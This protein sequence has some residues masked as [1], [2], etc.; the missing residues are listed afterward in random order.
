MGP[1]RLEL[2]VKPDAVQIFEAALVVW[3][4]FDVIEQVA[5]LGFRQ[6]VESLAWLRRPQF[7]IWLTGFACLLLASLR[8]QTG[9]CVFGH[10]TDRM[11]QLR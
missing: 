9:P 7:E 1:E 2:P 8:D 6:K 10:A 3:I 5:R 4:T 11:I